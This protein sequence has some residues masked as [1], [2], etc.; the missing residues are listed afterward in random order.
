MNAHSKP[1][2]LHRAD[3]DLAPVEWL[4]LAQRVQ[5]DLDLADLPTLAETLE[6]HAD[7]LLAHGTRNLDAPG[8]TPADLDVVDLADRRVKGGP[9]LDPIGEADLGRRIGARRRGILPTL[10]SWVSLAAGEMADVDAQMVDPADPDRIVWVVDLD[11]IVR[12]TRPGVTVA[13]EAGWLRMHLDWIAGQQWVTELAEEIRSIVADLDDLGV[14]WGR[15]DERTVLC[16]LDLAEML[17]VSTSTIRK[18]RSRGRLDWALDADG[19]VIRD[20]LGRRCSWVV[21]AAALIDRRRVEVARG[22]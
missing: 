11:G 14:G 20:G 12:A 17:D 3:R 1:T 6:R 9:I 19:E 15:V 10:E 22:A 4:T 2:P 13:S 8:R 16:D 21:E 5:L 7:D 18:W